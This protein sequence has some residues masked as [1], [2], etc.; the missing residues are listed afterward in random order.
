M[1]DGFFT[2][3]LAFLAG[4]GAMAWY[5]SRPPEA[6]A[7]KTPEPNVQSAGVISDLPAPKA[8]PSDHLR[9][10]AGKTMDGAE[11]YQLQVRL[12]EDWARE[13]PLG[14][15]EYLQD[16][17]W[18]AS[19]FDLP[20]VELARTNP[21]S[22]IDFVR[23]EGCYDAL[24]EIGSLNHRMEGDPNAILGVILSQPKGVLPADTYQRLF[25]AGTRLDPN[26]HREIHHITDPEAKM[27]AYKGAT[28]TLLNLNRRDE[29][30][31]WYTKLSD[32]PIEPAMEYLTL[33]M[34]WSH[35]P[36][37]FLNELPDEARLSAQQQ[38]LPHLMSEQS[39]EY[40]RRYLTAY[41][42][43]EWIVDY[44]Q[45]ARQVISS[46]HYTDQS[47]EE[48]QAWRDW[49]QALPPNPKLDPL[50]NAAIQRWIGMF[51]DQWQEIADLKSTGLRD[52]AYL[53]LLATMDL[54]ENADLIPDVM[55]QLSAP[56]LVERGEAIL[57]QRREFKEHPGIRL[58]PYSLDDEGVSLPGTD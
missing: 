48:G 39:A 4:L 25:N 56:A 13:D 8:T 2:Y 50:R 17:P 35:Q 16:R 53:T 46:S 9:V 22:L 10:L 28:Q 52:V 23:Q 49:G 26:F 19:T 36:V 31:V 33:A 29:Y 18:P 58:D 30:A 15:L 20:F 45:S 12:Y 38:L 1:K 43:E 27:A 32:L 34:I 7:E 44:I 5:H 14:L 57:K 37:T 11:W 21:A 40:Q 55:E 6:L 51:P 24:Q 47:L 41:V 42:E 3:F 54:K